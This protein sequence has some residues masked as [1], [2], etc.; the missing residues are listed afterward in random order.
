[1]FNMLID[2]NDRFEVKSAQAEL[3]QKPRDQDEDFHVEKL[4]W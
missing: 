4:S 3:F 1:M 2:Y